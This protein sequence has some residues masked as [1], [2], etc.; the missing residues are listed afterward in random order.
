HGRGN[1]PG[2]VVVRG[3]EQDVARPE[4]LG[5]SSQR[6]VLISGD[7]P[8]AVGKRG[9]TAFIVIAGG[10]KRQVRVGGLNQPPG[11]VV[12]VLGLPSQ[13]VGG[14]VLLAD[15]VVVNLGEA[16]IGHYSLHHPVAVVVE[17]LDG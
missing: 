15:G 3:R 12:V 2:S 7:M 10:L 8:G 11:I 14:D 13:C 5:Q 17:V 16:P 4:G 9:A 1:A 6:V